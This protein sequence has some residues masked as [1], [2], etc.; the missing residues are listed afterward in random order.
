MFVSFGLLAKAFGVIF[1]LES[2]TR[3]LLVSGS[4][5]SVISAQS[6]VVCIFRVT[7]R[8]TLRSTW[9]NGQK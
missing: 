4:P 8:Q 2:S 5:L 9:M 7:S 1:C 3:S 6:V